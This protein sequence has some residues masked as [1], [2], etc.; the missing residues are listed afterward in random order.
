MQLLV[1][2][3]VLNLPLAEVKGAVLSREDLRELFSTCL[4]NHQ[5]LNWAQRIAWC[6]CACTIYFKCNFQKSTLFCWENF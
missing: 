1:S 4:I 6:R 3:L 5:W 2:P